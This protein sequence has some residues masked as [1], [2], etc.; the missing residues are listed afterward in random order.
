MAAALAL[1]VLSSPTFQSTQR[2]LVLLTPGAQAG[3]LL[4]ALALYLVGAFRRRTRLRLGIALV[5]LG[6]LLVNVSPADPFFQTTRAAAQGMLK[7][8]MTPSLRSLINGIGA[9]WPMMV[10]AYFALR[11]AATRRR[12]PEAGRSLRGLPDTR[13]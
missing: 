4:G 1:R 3:L 12:S 2:L 6:L 13:Q 11:L 8:A 9:W 7:P 10:L 5:L